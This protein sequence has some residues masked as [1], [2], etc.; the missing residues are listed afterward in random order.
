M[1]GAIQALLQAAATQQEATRAQQ[2]AHQDAMRIYQDTLLHQPAA[3]RKA[4][5][6][7]PGVGLKG[8]NFQLQIPRGRPIIF[9]KK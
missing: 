8:L 9:F 7:H 3:Q 4:R 6:K 1:E 5:E 2:I